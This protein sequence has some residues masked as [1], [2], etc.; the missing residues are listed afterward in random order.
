MAGECD[1]HRNRGTGAERD[2]R[3]HTM[4]GHVCMDG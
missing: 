3:E 1:R 4:I 2:R